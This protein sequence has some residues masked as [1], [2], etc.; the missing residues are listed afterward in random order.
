MAVYLKGC[1][2]SCTWCHSPESQRADPELIY[3][4]ERC[5]L[6]GACISACPQ[7]AH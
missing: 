6:C 5:L 2:L 3:I 1:P 4:R 7:S